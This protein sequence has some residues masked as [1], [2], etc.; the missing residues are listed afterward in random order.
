MRNVPG[1]FE[2]GSILPHNTLPP[3]NFVTASAPNMGMSQ[4]GP[5]PTF[6]SQT[7]IDKLYFT[8]TVE[9]AVMETIQVP[10]EGT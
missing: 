3:K 1:T 6:Q 7:E 5:K 10:G 4:F 9:F 2:D 8:V